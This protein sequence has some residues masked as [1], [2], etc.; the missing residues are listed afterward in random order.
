MQ[1][2]GSFPIRF[3][4][5][6]KAINLKLP[7]I[8]KCLE[9]D[10][11][12]IKCLNK[13]TPNLLNHLGRI[14]VPG[15]TYLQLVWETLAMMAKGAISPIINVEFEDVRFLRATTMAPGQKIDFTIMV[16]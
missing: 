14:I 12:S 15:T 2:N 13:N 10:P 4:K 16:T 6:N 9:L 3:K 11:I 5:E 1:N 8:T 7:F